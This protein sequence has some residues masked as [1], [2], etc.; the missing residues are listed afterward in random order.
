[1]HACVHA[2]VRKTAFAKTSLLF[3]VSPFHIFWTHIFFVLLQP[4][5]SDLHIFHLWPSLAGSFVYAL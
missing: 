1:M 4:H 2:R 3:F 5:D